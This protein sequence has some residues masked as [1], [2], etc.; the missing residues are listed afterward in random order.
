MK[1]IRL[2][3]TTAL[4]T[5][6]TAGAYAQN[7]F[8][9]TRAGTVLLYAN[10]N[11]NG[12]AESHSRQTIKNVEG[13][14]NNMTISYVY[15]SLDKNKNP[16]KP[17]TEIPCTVI[18]KDGTVNL[19][20]SQMVAG[21]LQGQQLKAEITGV[22]ME[23]PSNLQPGQ[24]LKDAE[25]TLTIDM[26]VMKMITVIKM[27]DGKCLAIEDLT[28][29]AGTFNCRKITQ[30]VTTTVLGRNITTTTVSW[31]ALGIGTVKTESYDNKNK[32][33]NSTVLVE[34]K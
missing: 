23:L 1:P 15:E 14:G 17:P 21:Q 29:P 7:T 12:R 9:P 27:T 11:A 8:F 10:N 34:I 5:V 24:T 18:I 4:I 20:M 3:L 13:S 33:Q 31:Y 6:I 25:V 19:D 30:T 32:L 22:P 16:L 28:V 26:G 2:L